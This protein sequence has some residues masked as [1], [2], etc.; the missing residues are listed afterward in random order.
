[1]VLDR[2]IL[3]MGLFW[4]R[5]L[6]VPG[7]YIQHQ[8]RKRMLASLSPPSEATVAGGDATLA[9]A[10]S[11]IPS[12]TRRRKK[13]RLSIDLHGN[14]VHML[15]SDDPF[16]LV[17]NFFEPQSDEMSLT[18]T[19]ASAFRLG[20]ISL[21]ASGAIFAAFMGTLRILAPL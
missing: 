21:S 3:V 9:K 11:V 8:S 7:E 17:G 18:L 16:E 2:F 4:P 1:M 6:G 5:V 14:T 12:S 15:P 13:G 20:R 19:P 10:S